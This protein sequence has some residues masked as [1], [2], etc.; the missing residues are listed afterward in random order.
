M[1][2]NFGKESAYSNFSHMHISFSYL[3]LHFILGIRFNGKKKKTC[4]RQG[5]GGDRQSEDSHKYS[6]I[7]TNPH[8][9]N[10]MHGYLT[11]SFFQTI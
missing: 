8:L 2:S 4:T 10:C 7:S 3:V 9:A 6:E 5:M 11:C 1:Q